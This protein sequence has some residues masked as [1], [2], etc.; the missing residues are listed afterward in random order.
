MDKKLV[1]HVK[2]KNAEELQQLIIRASDLNNQLL[3]T[4]QQIS[5]FKLET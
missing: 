2:L 4:L 3:K 1:G 5:G